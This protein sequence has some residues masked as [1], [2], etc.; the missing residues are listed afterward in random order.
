MQRTGRRLVEETVK[1]FGSIDVLVNNAGVGPSVR[2]DLLEMTEESWDR[3]L[4]INTKGTMFL[5]QA[6]AK[7]M[8]TQEQTGE[9]RGTI[10]NISS[11]SA[12]VSSV[13]RGEY[14]VSKAGVSMLTP[15]VCRPAFLGRH[16]CA[17]GTARR[18]RDG[19][20][21]RGEGTL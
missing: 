20:D 7:Q 10:V 11:C 16:P 4:N 14:C 6:V 13:N 3:V 5:T 8:L 1:T 2:N 15:S 18:D 12:V 21:L 9:K 17:R 19:Y